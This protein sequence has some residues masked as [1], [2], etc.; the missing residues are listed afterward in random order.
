MKKLWIAVLLTL[1]VLGSVS[2][3]EVKFTDVPDAW[4]DFAA[5]EDQLR[6]KVIEK[7]PSGAERESVYL[8]E[9]LKHMTSSARGGKQ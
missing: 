6:E 3:V 8:K 5:I 1:C 2:A 4:G 7:I 9:N